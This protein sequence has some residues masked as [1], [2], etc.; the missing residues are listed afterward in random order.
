[1]RRPLWR[2]GHCLL[3]GLILCSTLVLG[4]AWLLRA[5]AQQISACPTGCFWA[6][7][8]RPAPSQLAWSR[9]SPWAFFLSAVFLLHDFQLA[10]VEPVLKRPG[11]GSAAWRGSP[12]SHRNR[13]TTGVRPP[14]YTSPL[15]HR[16]AA[17]YAPLFRAEVEGWFSTGLS[18]QRHLT[19]VE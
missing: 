18:A 10:N 19:C 11:L 14:K 1:M 13:A 9:H 7:E 5:E 8:E 15:N 3:M 16:P 2:L 4:K 17:V 12:Q 6:K